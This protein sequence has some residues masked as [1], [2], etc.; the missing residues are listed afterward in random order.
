MKQSGRRVA[1]RFWPSGDSRAVL[2]LSYEPDELTR[3]YGLH[4]ED[5]LDDL[6]ELKYAVT[7]LGD[8]SNI[9]FIKHVS[10]PPGTVVN[11]DPRA[12]LARERELLMDAFHLED[13]NLLWVAPEIE[14]HQA[15][16][17]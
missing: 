15:A 2:V 16:F 13:S 8:G 5:V 11:V 1:E 4:F 17:A 12:N 10:D 3:L 6:E 7:T 14:K 9:M